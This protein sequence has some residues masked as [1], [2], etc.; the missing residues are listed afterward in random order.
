MVRATKE[1]SPADDL[2]NEENIDCWKGQGYSNKPDQ[3]GRQLRQKEKK[4]ADSTS[5]K[6]EKL[7][8]TGKAKGKHNS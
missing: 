5:W 8:T 4:L 3:I 7:S 1:I 2:L 6:S